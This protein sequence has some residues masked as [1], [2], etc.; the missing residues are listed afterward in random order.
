MSLSPVHLERGDLLDIRHGKT[1]MKTLLLQ[2]WLSL[3]E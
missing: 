3:I 1:A 2:F